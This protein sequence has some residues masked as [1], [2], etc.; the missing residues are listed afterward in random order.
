MTTVDGSVGGVT[1]AAVADIWVALGLPVTSHDQDFFELGGESLTLVR[2]LARVQ[3]RWGLELPVDTIFDSEF[4]VAAAAAL[5]EREQL[6]AADE[7]E[8]AAALAELDGMSDE[9]VRA[10]LGDDADRPGAGP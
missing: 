10:L 8:I 7:E 4:T 5:I 3:D 2:F 9:E 6:A 1:E